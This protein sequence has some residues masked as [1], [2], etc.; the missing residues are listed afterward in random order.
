MKKPK[1]YELRVVKFDK[2]NLTCWL[3]KTELFVRTSKRNVTYTEKEDAGGGAYWA[4]RGEKKTIAV[5]DYFIYDKHGNY[6]GEIYFATSAHFLTPLNHHMKAP[7]TS[8]PY[9]KILKDE[10]L[11]SLNQP[12]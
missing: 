12:V 2:E 9:L 3:G 11:S 7:L 8:L 1:N 10:Y 5:T 6:I 4:G